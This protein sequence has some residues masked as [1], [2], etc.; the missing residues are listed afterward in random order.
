M[1]KKYGLQLICFG[2]G[3]T[4]TRDQAMP[5]SVDVIRSEI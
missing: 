2:D 4:E 3:V 1:R 5:F